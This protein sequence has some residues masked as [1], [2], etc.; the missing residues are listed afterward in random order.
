MMSNW[1]HSEQQQFLNTPIPLLHGQHQYPANSNTTL[2]LS[3]GSPFLSALQQHH[4]TLANN[5]YFSSMH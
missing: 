5:N 4:N 2:D 3:Q 1:N